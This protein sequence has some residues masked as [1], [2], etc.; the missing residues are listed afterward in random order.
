MMNNIRKH[1]ICCRVGGEEFTV[2]VVHEDPKVAYTAAERL[3]E[4]VAQSYLDPVGHIT[5]SIGIASW[6]RDAESVDDVIK[7]ADQKLY[8][9][10]NDG[11]NCTRISS[12]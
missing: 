10:K 3:R 2:F 11:R 4:A 7:L 9:A 5:V 8:E 1:D 6:P 12:I